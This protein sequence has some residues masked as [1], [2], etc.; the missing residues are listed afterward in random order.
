MTGASE[1]KAFGLRNGAAYQHPRAIW[2]LDDFPLTST[3]KIDRAALMRRARSAAN[4]VDRA[5]SR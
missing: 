4:T 2:F 3:N 5:S 1:L